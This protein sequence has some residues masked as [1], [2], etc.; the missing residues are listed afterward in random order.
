MLL[1]M[2]LGRYAV[3]ILVGSYAL[4]LILP[5]EQFSPGTLEGAK[6]FNSRIGLNA[7]KRASLF[8][9]KASVVDRTA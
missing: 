1:Q 7:E 3:E 8:V 6:T 5:Y 9:G 2:A 4:R